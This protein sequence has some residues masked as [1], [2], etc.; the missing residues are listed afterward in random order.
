MNNKW[1]EFV[2][3]FDTLSL[4]ERTKAIKEIEKEYEDAYPENNSLKFYKN[5]AILFNT[6]KLLA[7][8]YA[9]MCF[10]H[11]YFV[12]DRLVKFEGEE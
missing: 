12:D 3:K 7:D 6:L 5:A 8:K 11:Q 10:T 4:S 1:I 9:M 2:N